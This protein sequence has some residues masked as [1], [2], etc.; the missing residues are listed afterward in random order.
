MK[1]LVI[2]VAC[3]ALLAAAPAPDPL[4]ARIVADAATITEASF[5]FERTTRLEAGGK[6]TVRVERF[7][8]AA[9]PRW[10]L[11]SVDG[12][13]PTADEARDYARAADK[14][15][16]PNYGRLGAML[17]DGAERATAADGNTVYR[18]TRLPKGSIA[19]NGASMAK[20][21]VGEATIARAG[22]R[23][24][25]AQMRVFAPKPFRMRMVAKVDRFEAVTRYAPGADGRI[26]VVSQA[27]T[28]VGSML[29]QSGTMVSRATYAP[30]GG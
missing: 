8:P 25:V 12:R 14:Q 30:I 15:P 9:T 5:G 24:F 7:R 16:V 28:T 11:A 23:P 20:H 2:A 19:A 3:A 18:V 21:L 1:R 26:R 22:D 10:T 17:R 29:G 27:V 6:S 4:L 13:A